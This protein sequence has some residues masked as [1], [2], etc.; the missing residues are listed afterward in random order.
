[1]RSS[2]P[3]QRPSRLA[4]STTS[5]LAAATAI[6]AAV[7]VLVFWLSSASVMIEWQIALLILSGCLAAGLTAGLYRG[8][9]LE[10][11]GDPPGRRSLPSLGR[12]DWFN[13]D[14]G[15]DGASGFG[16]DSAGCLT[17]VAVAVVVV[18]LVVVTLQLLL[19]VVPPLSFAFYVACNRA[20]RIILARSRNC[21]GNLGRSLGYGVAYTALG[22]SL[23]FAATWLA[24]LVAGRL[25]LGA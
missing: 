19:L 20:L 22:M 11:P 2:A 12:G 15:A 17:T 13:L 3:P 5:V 14:F 1:V 10:R 9:R 23:V 18:V 25:G 16:D 6:V 4:L 24:W 7:F 21:R 8:V